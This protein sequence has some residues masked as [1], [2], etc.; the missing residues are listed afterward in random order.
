MKRQAATLP[1]QI[2]D[3]YVPSLPTE[4]D[5]AETSE[6]NIT[7]VVAAGSIEG[8]ILSTPESATT[9]QVNAAMV[10]IQAQLSG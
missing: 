10:T 7:P 8:D 5:S 4:D 1:F 3:V 6:N 9:E 2:A